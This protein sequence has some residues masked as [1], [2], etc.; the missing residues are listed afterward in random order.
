MALHLAGT[1][2]ATA[3]EL[4]EIGYKGPPDRYKGDEE[5]SRVLLTRA[6]EV[7]T[8]HLIHT[9][10]CACESTAIAVV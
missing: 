6:Q 1:R 10:L 3:F 4:L 8:I 7:S 9:N 5:F 2:D